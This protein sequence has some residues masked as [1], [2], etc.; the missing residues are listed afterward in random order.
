MSH[1]SLARKVVFREKQQVEAER[2]KA[3]TGDSQSVKS[4][5]GLSNQ[6]WTLCE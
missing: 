2:S 3:K 4:R 1:W 5:V 6:V